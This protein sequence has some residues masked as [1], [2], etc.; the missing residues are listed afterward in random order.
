MNNESGVKKSVF[1]PP[2]DNV[3]FYPYYAYCI[4]VSEVPAGK[5]TRKED[6][7]KCLENVYGIKG[8]QISHSIK[9]TEDIINYTYPFWRIV[10]DRGNLITTLAKSAEKQKERLDKEGIPLIIYRADLGTY[11]VENLKERLF[12]FSTLHITIMEN[13]DDS[14]KRINTKGRNLNAEGI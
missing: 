3:N 7:I 11:R 5:I 12:D 6:I 1:V 4:L 8:L 2:M 9:Y 13:E 10:S 14:I